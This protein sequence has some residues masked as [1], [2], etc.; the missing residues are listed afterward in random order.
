MKKLFAFLSLFQCTYL[1]ISNLANERTFKAITWLLFSI[2]CFDLMAVHIRYLSITYTPEELSFYRNTLG[3]IPSILLLYFTA[4][5]SLKLQ[6]YKIKQWKLAFFRGFIVA[7][8]QLLFYTAISKLELAT[9]A[10]LGQTGPIFIVI[11]AIVLYKEYV[12]VWRWAAICRPS[13]FPVSIC[14]MPP[15]QPSPPPAC[16]L[17]PCRLSTEPALLGRPSPIMSILC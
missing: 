10:T 8:A 12:G 11:L 3:L 15:S 13:M 6:D 17:L 4:E 16:G 7:L 14:C 2:I 5:L 1:G 9:V